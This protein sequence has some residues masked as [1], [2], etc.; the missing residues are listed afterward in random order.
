MLA[1]D[2]LGVAF[3]YGML[4]RVEVTCVCAPLIRKVVREA[5]GLQQRLKLA[6][7]GIL[8]RPKTYAKTVPV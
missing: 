5:E 3:A 1:L 7:D 6:K 8:S 4:F 2:F